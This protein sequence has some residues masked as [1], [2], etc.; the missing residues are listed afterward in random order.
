VYFGWTHLFAGDVDSR[1][2]LYLFDRLMGLNSSEVPQ[3]NPKQRPFDY[4]SVHRDMDR[5]ARGLTTSGSARLL[6]DDDGNTESGLLAPSIQN[7]DV[8]ED[9]STFVIRGKFG[10][11]PRS[12]GGGQVSINGSSQLVIKSWDTGEI[13]VEV[14]RSGP[15][16]AGDIVVWS[17][18][19]K[20]NTRRVSRWR[21]IGAAPAPSPPATAGGPWD[22]N[23]QFITGSG[24]LKW[25]GGVDLRFRGDLSSYREEAGG[26][27]K[28]RTI[29]FSI[30]QDSHGALE[31]SG[32]DGDNVWSG[33]AS[34]TTRAANPSA[35]NVVD[36][37]GEIDTETPFMRLALYITVVEG[38]IGTF[39][40][41]TYP[42][43]AVW[44]FERRA[45]LPR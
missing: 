3:E 12:S 23:L 22:F 20:S 15:N 14:P 34:I 8:R 11:D 31:A 41:I 38:M 36:G 26:D 45:A 2:S 44:G 1:A 19:R 4:V 40:D 27:P 42:I 18:G 16:A 13:V 37:V 21:G 6:Y 28:F 32:T 25:E 10:S 29:P 7:I 35:Q 39:E 24:T 17:K 5:P 33:V 30:A 43:P 9:S